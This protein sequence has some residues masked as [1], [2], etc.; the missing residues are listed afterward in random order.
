MIVGEYATRTE[1][2]RL[3]SAQRA[4]VA[5]AIPLPPFRAAYMYVYCNLDKRSVK[6]SLI[7]R[8]LARK[9]RRAFARSGDALRSRLYGSIKAEAAETNH[10]RRKKLKGTGTTSFDQTLTFFATVSAY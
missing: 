8:L 6:R 2:C 3:Q 10:A 4:C 5:L 9:P 1:P 7:G